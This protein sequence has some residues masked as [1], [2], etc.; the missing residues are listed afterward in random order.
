MRCP[1]GNR[2]VEVLLEGAPPKGACPFASFLAR[3]D[4]YLRRELKGLGPL[5]RAERVLPN[6]YW[7]LRYPGALDG[8]V[9]VDL[10]AVTEAQAGAGRARFFLDPR[11]HVLALLPP[12]EG[13]GAKDRWQIQM[14]TPDHLI[15]TVEGA[16]VEVRL[17]LEFTPA[18]SP[19][20][21][22]RLLEAFL[23]QM[24]AAVRRTMRRDPGRL[25]RAEYGG[26]W[27]LFY[28]G[29]D[30][31]VFSGLFGPSWR[32]VGEGRFRLEFI[33]LGRTATLEFYP[34]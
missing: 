21:L 17:D 27:E 22:R 6:A 13:P 30:E 34:L 16:P 12:P 33:R 14:G 31:P 18:L 11:A 8:F 3:T 5:T 2:E 7:R 28:E 32:A 19:E 26:T 23:S 10:E 9:P 24:K 29:L 15:C 25:V 1:L 4:A 20:H